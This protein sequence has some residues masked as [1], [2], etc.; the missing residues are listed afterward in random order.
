MVSR[1]EGAC[2]DFRPFNFHRTQTLLLNCA[3]FVVGYSVLA[4]ATGLTGLLVG[5]FFAGVATGVAS[6]VV[7][8]YVTEVTPPGTRVRSALLQDFSLVV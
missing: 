5:R 1:S 8:V 7:P 6:T 4:T 3:V 2:G